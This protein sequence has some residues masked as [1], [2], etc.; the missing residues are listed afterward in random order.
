[1]RVL[2][3]LEA[4]G[5]SHLI[6]EWRGIQDAML[7]DII[8]SLNCVP[9]GCKVA[10]FLVELA[11]QR[12]AR[13]F[14]VAVISNDVDIVVAS[15]AT[16]EVQWKHLGFMFVDGELL[17]PGLKQFLS[18]R[19]APDTSR[20]AKTQD[21]SR[22][23][24]RMP[25][26]KV[27]SLSAHL[28]VQ[29]T[30]MKVASGQGRSGA[31][32]QKKMPKTSASRADAKREE[33]RAPTYMYADT[34]VDVDMAHAASVD[35]SRELPHGAKD[36]QV[37]ADMG[38]SAPSTLPVKDA[39][40]MDVDVEESPLQPTIEQD[41]AAASASSPHASQEVSLEASAAAP[42]I[43]Q[44]ALPDNAA[45]EKDGSEMNDE[46]EELEGASHSSQKASGHSQRSEAPNEPAVGNTCTP[47]LEEDVAADARNSEV[48]MVVSEDE[49]TASRAQACSQCA[50]VAQPP[51]AQ[52]PEQVAE[53]AEE[54]G[55]RGNGEASVQADAADVV[56]PGDN[57]N[58][59]AASEGDA[60]QAPSVP[61]L[62]EGPACTFEVETLLGNWVRDGS[63][64][65]T[66]Q[67]SM[68]AGDGHESID[69]EFLPEGGAD[70]KP[71][72]R[73]A[74]A[75]NLNGYV[76]DEARSTQEVLR[77]RHA[78]SSAVR[79]WWREDSEAVP[80]PAVASPDA[81]LRASHDETLVQ[82]PISAA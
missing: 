57:S 67:L 42:T 73:L 49:V 23:K 53:M 4:D 58:S 36:T 75:W 3:L 43:A 40:C 82:V 51:R 11:A 70:P 15:R 56:A 64:K 24:C 54:L 28:R 71:I 20:S 19:Q 22:Y 63:R 52:L 60:I 25:S 1:V 2:T 77:W 81:E 46:G 8:A 5:Y 10:N 17:L 59:A 68:T 61:A 69:V 34:Q 37:E 44:S 18:L 27:S 21:L 39:T 32:L 14:E 72:V 12:I 38:I 7:A 31:S 30:V 35:R 65:H 16:P 62:A 79:T 55:Q 6:S 66:V 29:K 78:A 41:A 50:A 47:V 26:P 9:F 45:R 80:F 76:L 13:G 48:V 74:G 33:D